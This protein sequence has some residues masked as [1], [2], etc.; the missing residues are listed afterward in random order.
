MYVSV[1][2]NRKSSIC[3]NDCNIRNILNIVTNNSGNNIAKL[4]SAYTT[5]RKS[6]RA[7]LELSSPSICRAVL[8]FAGSC[9]SLR[10]SFSVSFLFVDI[11]IH[12]C[13]SVFVQLTCIYVHI[14]SLFLSR[15]IG[16]DR[17]TDVFDRIGPA[18]DVIAWTDVSRRRLSKACCSCA[19]IYPPTAISGKFKHMIKLDFSSIALIEHYFFSC[20]IIWEN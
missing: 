7:E 18:S 5:S 16:W 9:V 19:S 2:H 4:E 14:A 20:T 6:R 15:S 10:L 12:T 17:A 3:L 1:I 11:Y 13:C 8:L